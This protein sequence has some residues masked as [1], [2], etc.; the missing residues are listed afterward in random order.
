MYMF[1]F[2]L[3][4][5]RYIIYTLFMYGSVYSIYVHMFTRWEVR[6]LRYVS[7]I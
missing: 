1:I 7:F 4:L 2:S 6:P 5:T 3:G